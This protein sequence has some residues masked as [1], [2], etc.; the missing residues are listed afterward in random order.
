MLVYALTV[1]LGR[2]TLYLSALVW[3]LHVLCLF[4]CSWKDS[5][6]S[7]VVS[8]L[9][10][11]SAFRW[12]PIYFVSIILYLPW[13]PSLFRADG[14]SRTTAGQTFDEYDWAGKCL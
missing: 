14:A 11:L 7:T 4:I 12:I 9:R 1:Q 2:Y 5:H 10:K 13:I 8:R 3:I 6:V